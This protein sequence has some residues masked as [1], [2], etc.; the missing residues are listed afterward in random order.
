MSLNLQQALNLV[1]HE[2]ERAPA[3]DDPFPM[4]ELR[5]RALIDSAAALIMRIS[6]APAEMLARIADQAARCQ[7]CSEL[8]ED[9]CGKCKRGLVCDG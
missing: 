3:T 9:H 8:G 5:A 1:R 4:T 6:L 2:A 7:C